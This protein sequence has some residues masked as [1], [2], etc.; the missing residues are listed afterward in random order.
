LSRQR[1]T[2]TDK[3]QRNQAEQGIA[4]GPCRTVLY[5]VHGHS[6]GQFDSLLFGRSHEIFEL[7]FLVTSSV[8][9]V[10]LS[11]GLDTLALVAEERKSS[12]VAVGWRVVLPFGLCLHVAQVASLVPN[13]QAQYCDD[14]RY[15]F[16]AERH[17]SRNRQLGTSACRPDVPSQCSENIGVVLTVRECVR[18]RRISRD[19]S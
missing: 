9:S 7:A 15:G 17:V 10:Q 13:N 14:V 4:F 6:H 1:T 18:D 2:A 3:S 19:A 8:W 11:G 5:P 16:P 12:A